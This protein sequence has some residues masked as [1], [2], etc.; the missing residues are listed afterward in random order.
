MYTNKIG[1][2]KNKYQCIVH[3]GIILP[4]AYNEDDIPQQAINAYL[5][6]HEMFGIIVNIS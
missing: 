1:I 6:E 4:C 2:N 5:K 3:P